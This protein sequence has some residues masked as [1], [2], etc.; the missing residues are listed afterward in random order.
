M[1]LINL[2]LRLPAARMSKSSSRIRDDADGLGLLTRSI[3]NVWTSVGFVTGTTGPY[4][5]IFGE[6]PGRVKPFSSK[7]FAHLRVGLM[8]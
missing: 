7:S 2:S 8:S 4:N 6:N 3:F 1:I 5:L